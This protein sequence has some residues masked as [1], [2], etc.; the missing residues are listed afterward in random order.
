MNEAYID[1]LYEADDALDALR[2]RFAAELSWQT[3]RGIERLQG[4]LETE[5]LVERLRSTRPEVVA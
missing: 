3:I 2:R 4:V 1:A 5:R